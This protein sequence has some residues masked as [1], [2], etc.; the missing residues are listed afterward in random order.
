MKK[1]LLALAVAAALPAVAQA[2]SSVTLYGIADFAVEY[3]NARAANSTAGAGSAGFRL[4][5]DGQSSW[6]QSRFGVRGVEPLGNTGMQALFGVETR[7]SLDTGNAAGMSATSTQ[8]WN[9]LAYAGLKGGFGE[10]TAG[11]Q[12]TPG[13]YAW[14]HNDFTGNAG[15]SNWAVIGHAGVGSATLGQSG[16]NTSYGLVRADNSVMLNN[17]IGA[18][19]YRL[20]YSFGEA[21]LAD[22]TKASGD[23]VALSAVYSL[24]KQLSVSGFYHKQEALATSAELMDNAYGVAVKYDAGK[25]GLSLG[26]S[27]LERVAASAGKGDADTIALSA[28]V[29]AAGGK[30]FLNGQQVT[31]KA[32]AAAD[33]VVTHVGLSYVRP[34]SNRTSVYVLGNYSDQ[35]ELSRGKQQRV[36]VGVNHRF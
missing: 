22:A 36:S 25:M 26:Y 9:G 35:T 31:A 8:F 15:P 23:L 33:V 30:I 2:Q 21:K 4:N 28:Y 19:N 14:I 12:Y 7:I 1:S 10:L 34:L 3:V 24:N 16:S 6:N 5:A 32:P 17:T 11:R 20:M 13:F 29:N 27:Q 18:L